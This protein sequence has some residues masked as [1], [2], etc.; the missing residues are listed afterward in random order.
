LYTLVEPGAGTVEHGHVHGAVPE[1][2]GQLMWVAVGILALEVVGGLVTH[3]LALLS[4]A[5]HVLTDVL[6]LG[7]AHWAARLAERPPTLRRTYGYQRAGILTALGNATLLWL[8]AIGIVIEAL[9]RL[10]HPVAVSAGLM[11]AVAAVGLAGNLL[12]ALRL[13]GLGPDR[14]A[15]NVRSVWLHAMGDAAASAAVLITGVAIAWTHWL[16]LDSL[17]S[18]AIALLIGWG[19]WGIL[20]ETVNILMEGTPL[21]VDPLLV[22][23]AIAVDP[24]VLSCHHLH[25][26]SLGDGARA[27]SAH[28]V[29][30]DIPV[31]ESQEVLQRTSAMLCQRFGIAHSTLQVEAGPCPPDGCERWDGPAGAHRGTKAP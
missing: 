5:A 21:G 30:R 15:L 26:W 17:A 16:P 27:L 14:H 8:V 18:I 6:S 2:L 23:E 1:R 13:A 11:S 24:A 3:S 4:D 10:R 19:A 20:R 31:S 29:L 9:V 22:A 28:L 12:M 7:A 25:I